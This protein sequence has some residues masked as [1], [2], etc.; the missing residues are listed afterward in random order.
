MRVWRT[1]CSDLWLERLCRLLNARRV[2]AVRRQGS[3]GSGGRQKRTRDA[4]DFIE[5]ALGAPG[6]EFV[7]KT[8]IDEEVSYSRGGER[9][10]FWLRP[11]TSREQIERVNRE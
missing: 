2:A 7:A 4:L 8:G 6:Y 10:W 9:G 5:S 3:A 1:E 11:E